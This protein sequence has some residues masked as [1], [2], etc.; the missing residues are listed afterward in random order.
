MHD[1][2]VSTKGKLAPVRWKRLRPLGLEARYAIL[3]SAFRFSV[4][5]VRGYF[6]IVVVVSASIR[7]AR[8]GASLTEAFVSWK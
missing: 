3:A 5:K 2:Q 4:A 8:D 6:R 1:V 7:F